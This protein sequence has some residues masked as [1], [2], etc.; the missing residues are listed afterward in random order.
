[1]KEIADCP[2]AVRGVIF[3]MD[4][5]LCDSEPLIA[6]AACRMFSE[7]YGVEAVPLDFEPF[8]GTG[9]DRF[10]GGVAEKYGVT[11]S[12]ARDKQRTYALY[13]EMIVGRLQ[14]V[15]GAVAFVKHCRALGKKIAVA[16]SADKIKMDGNLKEIGLPPSFFDVCV[17]GDDVQRKKPDPETFLNAA[18]RLGLPTADCLVVEDAVNGVRAAK[19][20]GC[21]CLALTTSLSEA[22]LR[23][24]GA[25]AVRTDF[26]SFFECDIH[27]NA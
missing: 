15:A 3:D 25:D 22:A 12:P 2:A 8:I 18:A 19:A 11:L 21:V 14:P 6:E 16:T 24:A 26:R 9:E 1:M 23:A 4:G 5:V 7:T 10:L 17:T 20:A 13:L 27:R